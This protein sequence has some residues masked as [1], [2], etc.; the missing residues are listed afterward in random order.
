[1]ARVLN[2]WSREILQDSLYE[3]FT[4][5]NSDQKWTAIQSG[6]SHKM[7]DNRNWTVISNWTTIERDQLKWPFTLADSSLLMTVYFDDRSIWLTVRFQLFI[8]DF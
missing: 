7:N 8:F 2:E 6:R 3:R 1:M 4:L 5:V